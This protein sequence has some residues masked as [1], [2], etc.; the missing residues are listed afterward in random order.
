M[1]SSWA[2]WGELLGLGRAPDAA[3]L[4]SCMAEQGLTGRGCKAGAARLEL[5]GWSRRWLPP[6]HHPPSR[7]AD[8]SFLFGLTASTWCAPA[9]ILFLPPFPQAPGSLPSPPPHPPA[10]FPSASSFPCPLLPVAS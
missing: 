4:L 6:P 1:G 5:R 3:P 10:T 8:S 9:T 2:G 7:V